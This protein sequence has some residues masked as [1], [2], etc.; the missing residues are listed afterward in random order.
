MW[1]R[2]MALL[3]F[4]AAGWAAATEVELEVGGTSLR[5]DMPAGYVRVSEESPALT[6]YLQAAMPPENRLVEAFYTPADIQTLLAGGGAVKD[7]YFMVQA[8]RSLE[9]HTVSASDWRSLL[10]QATAVM[11]K[12]DVN[13]QLAKDGERNQRMSEA[14]GKPV[15]MEL[16]KV[17]APQVYVQTDNEA[18][19]VVFIPLTINVD[20]EPLTINAVCAGAMVLVANKPLMVYAY[21]A[22]ST[23]ADIETAK[24]ALGSSVDALLALNG[25]T[26][27]SP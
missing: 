2:G 24:Q 19:F 9:S 25:S 26:Q 14:A 22:S 21:R 5:Y 16:G 1:V 6:Q 17:A 12:V 18:R 8:N 7:T 20:G 3:L 15:R 4:F 23:P 10:V 27:R 11:D 13:A